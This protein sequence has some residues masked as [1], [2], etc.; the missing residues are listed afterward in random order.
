MQCQA[1]GCG[2]AIAA[3]DV[4]AVRDI[5]GKSAS[6][7][8][9]C[10]ACAAAGRVQEAT[11]AATAAPAMAPAKA[12][13]SRPAKHVAARSGLYC[14]CANCRRGVESQCLREG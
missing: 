6:K 14:S 11:K 1:H 5:P 10:A 8:D 7:R 13:A 4:F 9:V 3:G 12:R 2:A